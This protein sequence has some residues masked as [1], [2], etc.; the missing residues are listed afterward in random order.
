MLQILYYKVFDIVNI[1][2]DLTQ[3]IQWVGIFIS[4]YFALF[5]VFNLLSEKFRK[6]TPFSKKIH[7]VLQSVKFSNKIVVNIVTLGCLLLWD[8]RLLFVENWNHFKDIFYNLSSLFVWS[9]IVAL[10]ITRSC[11]TFLCQLHHLGVVA[12][13]LH[14]ITTTSLGDGLFRACIMYGVFAASA[15]FHNLYTVVKNLSSL[16]QVTIFYPRLCD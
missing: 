5:Q 11:M 16:S 4:I 7:I 15:F 9:D 1:P 13:Y 14:V 12:A 3:Y 2:L 8:E 10:L 6:R